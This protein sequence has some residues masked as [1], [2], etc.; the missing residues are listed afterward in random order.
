MTDMGNP[1]IG[2]S[3]YLEPAKWGAWDLP[4]ALIPWNYVDKLQEAGASVVLLPPD[5]TNAD[6]V[7]RLDGLVLAGGADIDPDRYGAAPHETTDRPRL[8]RDRSELIL[9]RAARAKDIPVL[10]ICRGMQMMA[11]AHGGSLHQHVPD[12]VGTTLHREEVGKFTVHGATFTEGSL[13]AQIIGATDFNVNSSHH[14]A[15]DSAGDLTVTGRA[16]DGIVEAL[17]DPSARFVLGIQ[18]H[19][20]FSNDEPTS[21]NIFN[22]FIEACTN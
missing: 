5:V 17:E 16:P 15:V 18:W 19:P 20:E 13:I 8:E 22:A 12:V 7:D 11:V 10:G 4:A 14:Q 2:L 6:A 9:Y 1:V 21:E 3:C